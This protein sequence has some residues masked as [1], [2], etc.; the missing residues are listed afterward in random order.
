[1]VA[2]LVVS[3][4]GF[5]DEFG[6]MVKVVEDEDA[7][8]GKRTISLSVDALGC[9]EAGGVVET[10]GPLGEDGEGVALGLVGTSSVVITPALALAGD[11]IDVGRSAVKRL[12]GRVRGSCHH[13]IDLVAGCVIVSV[14]WYSN[15]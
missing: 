4:R 8:M 9:G 15:P 14:A 5:G 6:S 13:R 3:G 7:G 12:S 11:D 2:S 10:T 1:M